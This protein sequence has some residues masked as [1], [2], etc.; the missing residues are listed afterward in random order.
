MR[1]TAPL[2]GFRH[3]IRQLAKGD[4]LPDYSVTVDDEDFVTFRNRNCDQA[5]PSPVCSRDF[6][7]LDAETYHDASIVAPGYD[8]YFLEQ[9]W[10]SW[11][12][13]SGQPELR[14]PDAAFIG[15]CRSRHA[16]AAE[17][18]ELA[19]RRSGSAR[20]WQTGR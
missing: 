15:F 5:A 4:H 14:D 2:K 18:L 8:V 11:W 3:D 17:S 1:L 12:C 16:A 13:E 6:P 9:E 19:L 10:Q 20:I 7:K